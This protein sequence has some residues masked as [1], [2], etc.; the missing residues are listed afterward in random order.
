MYIPKGK[1]SGAVE[2]SRKTRTFHNILYLKERKTIS[3][4][5][6]IIQVEDGS[7]PVSTHALYVRYTAKH[8]LLNANL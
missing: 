3:S 6:Q 7:V 4:S 1:H 2:V 8:S 5:H